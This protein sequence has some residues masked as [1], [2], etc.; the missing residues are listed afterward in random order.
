[1]F[2]LNN[3]FLGFTDNLKP[4]QKAKVEKH[5]NSLIS[6]NDTV[7]TQKDWIFQLL[8][9][10]YTPKLEENYSYYSRK[11]DG[12][13][14]PKNLYMLAKENGSFYE[15]SK[16]GYEFAKYLIKNGF[17]DIEKAK[18]YI[19]QERQQKEELERLKR[20]Q[21]EKEKRKREE[22]ERIRREKEERERQEKI[23]QWIEIGKKYMTEEVKN[24]I[25]ETINKHWEEIKPIFP[26]VNKEDFTNDCINKFTQ[27]LGNKEF[28]KS[29]AHYL[30][31]DN[32][33]KNNLNNKI[34]KDI[35]IKLFKL[36]DK[37]DKRT[38]TYKIKAFYDGRE[39][40][41]KECKKEIFYIRT[42]QGFE[43]REGEK[44]IIDNLVCFLHV[45]E[46]GLYQVTEAKTG[47]KITT[48]AS[49]KEVIEKAKQLIEKNKSNI[50]NVIKKAIS[51]FGLS[52]LYRDNEKAV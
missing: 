50:D 38:V 7:L 3:S 52:P 32:L 4:L 37:D 11:K 2:E 34:M 6:Y 16:T 48:D 1:M 36:T 27:F 13:T 47:M 5:L 40:K 29:N 12:Y 23:K 19:E 31:F 22:Q 18:H 15:V 35:Y 9:N 44:L 43:K 17:T 8:Q 10:G 21:E 30:M 20:E 49:K 28:I 33:N 24:I 25:T 45:N 51:Q 41:Q 42:K 46:K 14:K 39:Y 26:S